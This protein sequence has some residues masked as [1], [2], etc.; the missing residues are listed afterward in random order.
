MPGVKA[1]QLPKIKTQSVL[2]QIH[3]VTQ[4][5]I[6]DWCK[7]DTFPPKLKGGY[8]DLPAI[9][10]WVRDGAGSP[11]YQE[12]RTL[13]LAAEREREELRLAKDRGELCTYTDVERMV[14]EMKGEIC[15]SMDKGFHQ[16]APKLSG[17][18]AAAISVEMKN[19]WRDTHAKLSDRW[20]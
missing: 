10:K 1:E 3:G 9:G 11:Q 5:T 13:K 6:K 15:A 4:N 20:K 8:F 12:E 18:D 2:A 16:L 14:A 19:F 17:L 7:L